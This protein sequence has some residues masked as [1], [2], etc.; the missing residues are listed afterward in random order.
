MEPHCLQS[1]SGHTTGA[2]CEHIRSCAEASEF[3]CVIATREADD[4]IVGA[5]GAEYD[6]EL[7]RAWLYGPHS[8]TDDWQV[9]ASTLLSR[10]LAELPSSIAQWDAY[11][12]V[13]NERGREFF[14]QQGFEEGEGSHEYQLTPG[15]APAGN[16]VEH[17]APLEKRHEASLLKL[18][19][20]LFPGTYYSGERILKMNG[21]THQVFAAVESDELAG[22]AIASV[23]ASLSAGDVE[24]LGVRESS[25]GRGYGRRLLMTAADW[26][27]RQSSEMPICLNVRDSL[28]NARGLYESVGFELRFTGVGLR[29]GRATP[30]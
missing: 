25:R 22:F 5:A 27:R 23:A 17:C 11:L 24:F 3:L 6:F 2:L 20:E 26:L 8:T 30:R 9:S 19:D 15:A 7:G 14:V 12:N 21:D 18:Y 29:K 10:L 16:V 13:A 28:A 4:E 1:W